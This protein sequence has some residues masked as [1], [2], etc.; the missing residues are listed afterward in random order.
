[1]A[2]A[3]FQNYPEFVLRHR[4]MVLL[5]ATLIML[6]MASGVRFIEN[7][8]DHR[9]I[10][11]KDD[12]HIAAFDALEQTYTQTNTALIAAAP[13]S[14]SV[15][16]KKVLRTIEELTEAAWLVPHSIRVDS[17][18]NYTHTMAEGDDL[19][20]EPLVDRDTR[21]DDADILRIEQ[22]A[23]TAP[24]I[25]GRL[26]SMDG[27]VAGVAI[28]FAMPEDTGAAV[29]EISDYIDS[30][31]DE[32]RAHDPDIDYYVTGDVILGRAFTE[33]NNDDVELLPV[34][35]LIIVIITGVL[36]RSVVAT[37]AVVITLMY[38]V[39]TAMGFAGWIGTVF[40]P[41]SSGTPV[42]ITTVAVAHVIHVASKTLLGM[43]RGLDR[44]Q[45]IAGSVRSN[46]WPVFLSSLTTGI[47]FLTLNA[48]E[49][50]PFR[51]LGNLVAFGV[52]CAF[53]F[54]MTLLPAVLS[55]LPIRGRRRVERTDYFDRLGS[56]VIARSRVLIWSVTALAVV[57]SMGIWRIELTDNF[58][59][60]LDES[61]QF[62]QDTDF[63]LDNLTGIE[64]LEYSLN[65]GR[66]DGITDPSYLHK[67][68]AFAQWYRGQPE[69]AHVQAFPDV[70]KRLNKNMNGDDPA[71]FR[72]PDDPSLAAQYLLLYEFSLPQGIDLNDRMDVSKSE[73][74][75]TATVRGRLPSKHVR[76][77]DE[78][79]QR[80]LQANV[81][82]IAGQATGFAVA[83]AYMSQ[84][85]I[86]RLLVGMSV[87]MGLISII[88]LLIFRSI[89]LGLVSLVPN[90]VPL[91][92]SF[93]LW[94]YAVGELGLGGTVTCVIAFGIVVDD[95]VHFLSRYRD[96]RREG[97]CAPDAVRS[98]F[99]TVG[100]A[101]WTTTLALSAGFLVLALSGVASSQTL[102]IMVA[103]TLVI[104][105]LA[106]FL[107][108]PALLIATERKKATGSGQ[109][110]SEMAGRV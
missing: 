3:P 48:S 30:M 46:A 103:M 94:G 18:A 44:Q 71:F 67:V 43:G 20:V 61:Y 54:S 16:S 64:T 13:R 58:T 92:M 42:I 17:L 68:D 35:F 102:G 96:A 26:V 99:R 23:L 93:G 10:F 104:A 22:T 81:P 50:P 2:F 73:T 76:E 57:L 6:P 69:I 21:L 12:P 74:R 75:L 59:K 82:E 14:G 80:W 105:L 49:A 107:L 88:L 28:R 38:I 27:R 19:I 41:A 53:V 66:E 31:L 15:F 84:R 95:T 55:I 108:L 110:P 33:A 7:T 32:T 77:L 100:H 36:L 78:R 52:L 51:D 40:T 85:N 5:V 1:M 70:I 9:A 79:A 45:A 29:I 101:L 63:V 90:F 4:W 72:I 87:A 39:N 24:D 60:H 56:F 25:A 62:R 11:G 47:G 83:T 89:R 97:L 8:H 109:G 37:V 98:T 106:D 65:S 91:T 34:M 86:N